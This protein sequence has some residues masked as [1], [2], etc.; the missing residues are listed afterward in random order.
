MGSKYADIIFGLTYTSLIELVRGC[1]SSGRL[2]LVRFCFMTH[3]SE[4]AI[5]WVCIFAHRRYLC[6]AFN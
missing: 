6:I 4:D 2:F 1:S 3:W 5:T